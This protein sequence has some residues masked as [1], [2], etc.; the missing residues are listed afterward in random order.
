MKWKSGK[1]FEKAPPGSHIAICYAVIDLG[2][3]RHVF[4]DKESMSRDVRICWELPGE[5]MVGKYDPEA[6]GKP[7]M[8]SITVKQSLHPK[9]R[10]RPI[11]EGWRGR[12][13][14]KEE[15]QGFDP[16]KLVGLPCRVT[17]VEDGDFI[18]VTSVAPLGKDDAKAMKANKLKQTNPSVYFSLDPD[19][20]NQDVFNELSQKTQEKIA[21]SPEYLALENGGGEEP[22]QDAP[23]EQPEGD[24]ANAPD[25][26]DVPF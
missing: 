26:E 22:Q 9:S 10:L 23:E 1:Q 17:L 2:T 15:E 4:Q 6:K 13:F 14:T 20:F 25:G 16:H 8:V 5:K 19:E 3:Q 24:P 12:K 7:F 21:N 11:L 18:N